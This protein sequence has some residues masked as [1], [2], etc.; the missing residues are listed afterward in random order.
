MIDIHTHILP[1]MDD[2]ANSVDTSKQLLLMEEEQ[3]VK[4][5]VLSS[6]YYGKRTVEEFIALRAEAL[7]K[8]RGVIPQGMKVRLGAEVLMT[9]I[10]DPSDE[11]LC[12]LAIEGTKCVLLEFPFTLRWS[13]LLFERISDFIAETGYT[14]II[15]HTERYMEVMRNPVLVTQLV[16]MG[17]LIQLNSCAFLEK[18]TKRLAFALVKHGLV[19]CLGTDAHD[20]DRRKPDYEQAKNLLERLGYSAE[21]NELQWQMKKIFAGEQTIKPYGVVKKFG[22]FYY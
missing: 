21:W 20:L 8:I 1:N 19:H 10:N 22:K 12:A 11:T 6:H 9:G 16:Q 5:V 15:A 4:E 18:H 14:P 17:C 3:G 7:E 2:G 13:P